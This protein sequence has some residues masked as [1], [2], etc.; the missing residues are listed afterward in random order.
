MSIIDKFESSEHRNNI[1]HLASILNMATVDGAINAKE[2]AIIKSFSQK[3]GITEEE[4]III[5]KNPNQYPVQPNNSEEVR[6]ELLFDLFN[7]IYADNHIDTAEKTLVLKYAI[8]L[9]FASSKAEE[10]IE[11]SIKI[12]EGKLDFERYSSLIKN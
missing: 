4:Y 6:L 10:I 3:L 7:I 11:K 9:G 1:A 2:E 8:G 5:S 12:F